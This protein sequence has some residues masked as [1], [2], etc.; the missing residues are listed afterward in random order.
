MQRY[1]N[2]LNIDTTKQVRYYTSV[3]PITIKVEEVPFYYITREGD[4]LD[5][6]ANT[7]YKSPNLWW[8]I[9]QAN[10]LANGSIAVA[11]GVSLYIPTL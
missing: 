10:G 5:N 2:N 4:R 8:V 6:I 9:A 11:S 7:F 3:I 1:Q